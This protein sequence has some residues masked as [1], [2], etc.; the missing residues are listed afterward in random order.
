MNNN[1]VGSDSKYED[2]KKIYR[3][4]SGSSD[5]FTV[6]DYTANNEDV[7]EIAFELGPEIG[8][9][10]DAEDRVY[11]S[12]RDL[13]KGE[14]LELEDGTYT[15]TEKGKATYEL[16][17]EEFAQ[18]YVLK[19]DLDGLLSESI[20]R[21]GLGL[22]TEKTAN[23]LERFIDEKYLE[24]LASNAQTNEKVLL[25]TVI[26]AELGDQPD[27]CQ[28]THPN[29][30][31][32]LIKDYHA[33]VPSYENVDLSEEKQSL[34]KHASRLDLNLFKAADLVNE[35][36]LKTA[37]FYDSEN[38]PLNFGVLRGNYLS[39]AARQKIIEGYAEG[40]TP[41]Q[42]YMELNKGTVSTVENYVD[43]L[44]SHDNLEPFTGRSTQKVR[45]YRIQELLRSLKPLSTRSRNML[46]QLHYASVEEAAHSMSTGFSPEEAALIGDISVTEAKKIREEE[47]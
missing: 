42:I 38:I 16:L 46:D 47:I 10:L 21:Y 40:L 15:T 8:V 36:P 11:A 3:S 24:E 41:D 23:F 2:L 4:L 22:E 35:H 25:E 9:G 37:R 26:E 31:T 19:V 7:F 28:D 44:E 27:K 14:L 6:F 30:P 33:T 43:K 18:H 45:N 12:L 13:R 34:L 29:L 32:N 5:A 39:G 20:Q 17:D 1:M